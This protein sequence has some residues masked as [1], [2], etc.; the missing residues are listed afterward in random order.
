MKLYRTLDEIDLRTTPCVFTFGTFDGVH[1]GHQHI[2][3]AVTEIAKEK[4][5]ATA[6]LTF[7]NHP[8]E[9]IS[10]QSA[11]DKLT[12]D[13]HKIALLSSFD[14]VV[15]IAFNDVLRAI[16]A[17]DFIG[18]LVARINIAHMVVGEDVRFG[19]RGAGSATLLQTLASEFGFICTLVPRISFQGQ[20][21]S[22]SRIRSLVAEARFS[23][24]AAL[25]ARPFSHV[26]PC[27]DSVIDLAGYACPPDGRYLVA[28][29]TPDIKVKKEEGWKRVF[30]YLKERKMRIS[31]DGLQ[32]MVQEDIDRKLVEVQYLD[33]PL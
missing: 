33:G 16:D 12:S 24:V 6:L 8:S 30:V 18:M 7:S 15:D 4:R 13:A 5:L 9:I 19:T 25:L 31:F 23:E 2:F 29:R 10:P 11:V 26:L 20:H 28:I 22:S 14:Y 27:Q 17:R 3:K 32:E 1:V 21:I